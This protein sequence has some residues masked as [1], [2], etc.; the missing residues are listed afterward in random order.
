[1]TARPPRPGPYDPATGRVHVLADRCT[2][3]VFR[4]G[5]LMHLNPGRLKDLI[6]TNTASGS[7]LTCHATLA[8]WD[9]PAP[10]AVCRGFYDAHPTPPLLLAAALD[11]IT[12]DP[13]PPP[14]R[15]SP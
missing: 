5:N 11:M 6:E 7:A 15:P 3:C 8:D 2:T 4:P 12:F 14:E 13:A 10:P 1:M 9:A